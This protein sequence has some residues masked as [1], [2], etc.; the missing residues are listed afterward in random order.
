MSNE[1]WQQVKQVFQSALEHAPGERGAF[2]ADACANDAGLRREVEILLTSFENADDD[3]FMQQAAI[4]DD[5]RSGKQT[6][7]RTMARPL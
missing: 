4:G 2:L 1:K 5:G 3:S 6:R 7:N